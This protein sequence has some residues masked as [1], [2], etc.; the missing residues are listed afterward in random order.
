LPAERYPPF[1]DAER[2]QL[3]KR[4]HEFGQR[5]KV[6]L[7]VGTTDADLTVAVGAIDAALGARLGGAAKPRDEGPLSDY[8]A[9]PRQLR[10]LLWKHEVAGYREAHLNT[11]E[12][13]ERLEQQPVVRQALQ[14]P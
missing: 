9:I 11:L 5:L 12:L 3:A 4:L 6:A 8:G 2:Q 1:G 14:G 7:P 13:L 10:A